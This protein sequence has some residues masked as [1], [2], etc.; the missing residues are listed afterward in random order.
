MTSMSS[1]TKVSC[2]SSNDDSTPSPNRKKFSNS[3]DNTS[4]IQFEKYRNSMQKEMEALQIKSRKLEATIQSLEIE[5]NDSKSL[6]I[7]KDLEL[8]DL[9][10]KNAT[11]QKTV[12]VYI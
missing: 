6:L 2:T 7:S 12:C 10:S 5:K 4:N 8:A 11:L 1:D 9:R 3:T